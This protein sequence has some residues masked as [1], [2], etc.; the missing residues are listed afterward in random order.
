MS[1]DLFVLCPALDPAVVERFNACQRPGLPAGLVL[2]LQPGEHGRMTGT[3]SMDGEE[4][5]EL[6]V[7][8]IAGGS[9]ASG[10]VGGAKG[11][12]EV[13]V[14]SRGDP[15]VFHVIAA[16][17]EVCGGWVF[18]PQGVASEVS[19]PVGDEQARHAQSGYYTPAITRQLAEVLATL[20]P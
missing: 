16:L 11:W 3:I 2:D 9:H 8:P 20:D 1:F 12:I 15:E 7:E 4:W 19:L 5:A 17:A 6:Y 18:D 13:H 14:P 10:P